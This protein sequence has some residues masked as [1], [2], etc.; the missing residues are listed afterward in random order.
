[1]NNDQKQTLYKDEPLSAEHQQIVDLVRESP[2]LQLKQI[3]DALGISFTT[4]RYYCLILQAKGILDSRKPTK[5]W[6]HYFVADAH[7]L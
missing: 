6:R 4:A 2:G 7:G 5:G 3:S 1:V